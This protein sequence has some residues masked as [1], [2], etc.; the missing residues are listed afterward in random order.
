MIRS[1]IIYAINRCSRYFTNS[2]SDHDIVLKRI[3][4]YLV[5][6]K[7]L[8]LRFESSLTDQVSDLIDYT[9]ASYENCLN[10]RRS[11]S[12]YVY[13]LNNELIS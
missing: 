13:L 10:T 5:E 12:A 2:T 3:V 8:D 1:N 4:R 9:D 11:T 6:S 7:D